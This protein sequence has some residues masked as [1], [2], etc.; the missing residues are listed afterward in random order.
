M[1][2]EIIDFSKVSSFISAL[3]YRI[4]NKISVE[5]LRAIAVESNLQQA[6]NAILARLDDPDVVEVD[7][8]DGIL[9]LTND[10]YQRTTN[11]TDG[12]RIILPD[13][14]NFTEI[15]LYFDSITVKNLVIPNC[16]WRIEP[17]IENGTSFEIIAVYNTVEWLVNILSYSN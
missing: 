12:T 8:I 16:K 4:G 3:D 1:A 13:V 5:E 15:H 2:N 17:N 10:R 6:I 14:E 9:Y 7:T 11:I